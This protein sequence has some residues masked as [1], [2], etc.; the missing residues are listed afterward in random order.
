MEKPQRLV[1]SI[2]TTEEEHESIR[3]L[4]AA[5]RVRGQRGGTFGPLIHFL[6][7][8]Y[9]AEPQL[10]VAAIEFVAGIAAGGDAGELYQIWIEPVLSKA[11]K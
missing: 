6:L 9:Q 8:T 2:R 11:V 3:E 4:A 10:F 1:T 5:L 7:D